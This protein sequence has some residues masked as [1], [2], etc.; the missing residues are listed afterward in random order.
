V[1]SAVLVIGKDRTECSDD[2]SPSH[3]GTTLYPLLTCASRTLRTLKRARIHTHLELNF[4]RVQSSG[5]S[6]RER[7]G[8]VGGERT[9]S[10]KLSILL[11]VCALQG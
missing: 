1:D 3:A 5:S 4:G 2:L 9:R 7:C 11:H 10:V 8:V 6:V